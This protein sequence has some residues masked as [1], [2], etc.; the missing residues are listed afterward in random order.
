MS[1]KDLYQL[2]IKVIAD[3]KQVKNSIDVITNS[4]KRSSGRGRVLLRT[5]DC[6]SDSYRYANVRATS[7]V[8]FLNGE[9]KEHEKELKVIENKIKLAIN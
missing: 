1:N 6:I 9:L 4:E 2:A 8:Q 7:Y 5:D 3:I